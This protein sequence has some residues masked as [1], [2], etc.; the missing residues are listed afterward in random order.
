M[1]S[2]VYG[3]VLGFGALGLSALDPGGPWAYPILTP[4]PL[5]PSKRVQTVSSTRALLVPLIGDI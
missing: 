1:W 4:N 3:K 2:E 5:S